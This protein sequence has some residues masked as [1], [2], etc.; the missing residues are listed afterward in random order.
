MPSELKEA[1]ED[2]KFNSLDEI[3]NLDA[4]SDVINVYVEHISQTL[5]SLRDR[6]TKIGALVMEPVMLGAGG[7]F[8]P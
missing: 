6:G 2:L 8:V 7:F 4:R 1:T 5:R 3:F